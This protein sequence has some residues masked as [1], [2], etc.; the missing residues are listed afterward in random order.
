MRPL[1]FY[2]LG[3]ALAHSADSETVQRTVINRLYYGLHHE[4]CCRFFRTNPYERPLNRNRRHAD[5]RERFNESLD[6]NSGDVADL[7]SDLM[8]LRAESD[9]Q[10]APPL[11][12]RNR[13]YQPRQFMEIAVALAEQLLNALDVYSQGEA[14]D[15]CRCP[16]SY[17][18]F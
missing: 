7:L 17:S 6:P 4:A 10:L 13:S 14:P 12:Y 2:R 1:D 8:R 9:Y 18:S 16:E 5:L 3:T 11:R 15:G